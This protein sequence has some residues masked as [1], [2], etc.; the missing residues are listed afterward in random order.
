MYNT[1]RG[2][3]TCQGQE[4]QCP[5]GECASAAAFSLS[6]QICWE[7]STAFPPGSP[8]CHMYL[9]TNQRAE[10]KMH[11]PARGILEEAVSCLGLLGAPSVEELCAAR[12]LGNKNGRQHFQQS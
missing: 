3:Q 7:P 5:S 10:S 2:K 11:A 1:F 8:S 4:Q 6:Q 9:F 12:G